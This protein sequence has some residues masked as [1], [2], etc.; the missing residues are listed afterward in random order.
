MSLVHH[1]ITFRNR[2]HTERPKFQRAAPHIYK[3]TLVRFILNSHKQFQIFIKTHK[4][5]RKSG[6][7]MFQIHFYYPE[8]HLPSTPPPLRRKANRNKMEKNI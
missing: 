4:F 6:I 1:V 8:Y 2:F 7:M 5:N 3:E